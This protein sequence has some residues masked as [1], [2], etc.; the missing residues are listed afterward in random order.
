VLSLTA[1]PRRRLPLLAAHSK[2]LE[3]V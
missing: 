1:T 3:R 2:P